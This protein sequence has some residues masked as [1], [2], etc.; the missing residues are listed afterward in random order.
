[1][2][3]H[4]ARLGQTCGQNVEPKPTDVP[5]DR[6]FRYKSVNTQIP[7]DDGLASIPYTGRKLLPTGDRSSVTSFVGLDDLG[8]VL[9]SRSKIHGFKFG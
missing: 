5:L 3:D 1:M 9:A 7:H 2:N 8:N 6:N 4:P